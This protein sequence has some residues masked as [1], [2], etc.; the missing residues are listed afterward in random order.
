M[1]RR[2]P[3]LSELSAREIGM[4]QVRLFLPGNMDIHARLI[5]LPSW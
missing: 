5:A 1:M 3:H 2:Y 4:N